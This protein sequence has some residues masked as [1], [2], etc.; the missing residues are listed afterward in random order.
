MMDN[1]SV[2]CLLGYKK[3]YAIQTLLLFVAYIIGSYCYFIIYECLIREVSL[4]YTV[5]P[6]ILHICI[7]RKAGQVNK[8]SSFFKLS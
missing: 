2:C 3:T 7:I 5:V 6:I 8:F 1:F 4:Y